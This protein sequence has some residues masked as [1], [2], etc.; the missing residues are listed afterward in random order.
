MRL[1]L[2]LLMLLDLGLVAYG[3]HERIASVVLAGFLLAV[4]AGFGLGLLQQ[5]RK[6]L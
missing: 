6:T 1:L 3:V 5:P 4:A 2:L